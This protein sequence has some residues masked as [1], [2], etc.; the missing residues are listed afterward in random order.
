MPRVTIVGGGLAGMIAALRLAERGFEVDLYESSHRLGGKAGAN[1][2]EGDWDEHGYHIFPEWYLNVWKL[3]DELGIREEFLDCGDFEQLLPGQYPNY[4]TLRNITSWRYAWQNF[5]SGVLPFWQMVLFFYS[6]LDLVSQSY[7]YRAYLD[8]ITINGFVRSRFYRTEAVALQFQDLMLKGISC[9]STEVSAMTMRNVLRYWIQYPLPMYRILRGDLQQHFI[10]PFERKLVELGVRIHPQH[11]LKK[12]H[13][14]DK[15]V[16]RIDLYDI[17]SNQQIEV[18]VEQLM[19]AIPIEKLAAMIDDELYAAA[20]S[21]GR[22]RSLRAKAMACLNLYFKRKLPNIPEDHVNLL[23]SKYGLS[24]IDV[25]QRWP[26]P[27]YKNTVLNA[28][29]SHFAPLETLSDEAAAY[30]LFAD[31]QQFIPEIQWDDVEKWDFQPHVLEPLFMNDAGAWHFRPDALDDDDPL[32]SELPNLYLA[33]DYC[34]SHVDLVCME[35]AITTGLRAAESLRRDAGVGSEIE[36][37]IAEIPP[38]WL[39]TLGKFA[40]LP[41]AALAKLMVL[42]SGQ[43]E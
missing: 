39:M 24:F 15:R 33:G 30:E 26:G 34:R 17:G 20:P 2:H 19:I 40:L 8:Q 14:Q 35:G 1:H 10:A 5:T 31:L 18:E 43:R 22:L 3:V 27:S 16:S 25:S 21:I 36:I 13:I 4:K 42:L 7:A 28:I 12:L 37:K 38:E 32:R 6:A 23:R 41:V 9:P 29:A 11:L